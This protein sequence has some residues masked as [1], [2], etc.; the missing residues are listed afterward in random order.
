MDC[1]EHR[2]PW[3]PERQSV[4]GVPSRSASG[5]VAQVRLGTD[6]LPEIADGT[7]DGDTAKVVTV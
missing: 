1:R 7:L 3:G 6:R 2:D 5:L 4:Q